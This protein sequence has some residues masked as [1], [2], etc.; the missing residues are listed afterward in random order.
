MKTPT[1]FIYKGFKYQVKRMSGFDQCLLAGRVSPIVLPVMSIAIKEGIVSQIVNMDLKSDEGRAMAIDLALSSF[2]LLAQAISSIP[3]KEM[4]IIYEECMRHLVRQGGEGRGWQD[5][6]NEQAKALMF[7]DIEG[8][9][10]MVLSIKV[11]QDQLGNFIKGALSDSI[12][13]LLQST[14]NQ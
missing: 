8:V 7:E 9:D 2:E 5:V 3:T 13:G 12:L 14:T 6:F 4:R 10:V 1:E 11:I